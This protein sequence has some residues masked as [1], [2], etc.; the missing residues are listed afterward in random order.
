MLYNVPAVRGVQNGQEVFLFLLPARTLT[1]LPIQ[2]E[3]FD[4]NRSYD[5][6]TQGYQRSA[7]KN[8]ARRFSRYLEAAG[9][10]SPTALMLNDR[11]K[12]SKFDARTNTLTFDTEKGAI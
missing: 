9:A 5:D 1:A 6:A 2:V 10:I 11:N 8:R 12:V 7:E 3:Q 4:P